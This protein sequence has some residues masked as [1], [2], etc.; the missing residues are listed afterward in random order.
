M[1]AKGQEADAELARGAT[2]RLARASWNFSRRISGK[3]F[4]ILYLHHDLAELPLS[5]G[6][7]SARKV[8]SRSI[9][10]WAKPIEGVI[11]MGIITTFDGRASINSSYP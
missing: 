8:F 3:T 10:S 4:P 5:I 11:G 1:S 2:R 9:M 7:D 6:P